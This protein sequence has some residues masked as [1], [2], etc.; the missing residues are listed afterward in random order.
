M[1]IFKTVTIGVACGYQGTYKLLAAE[2]VNY[3]EL[4]GGRENFV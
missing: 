2:C 1:W 4:M 3:G